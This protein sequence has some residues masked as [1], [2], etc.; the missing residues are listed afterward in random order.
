MADEGTDNK[1]AVVHPDRMY[2]ISGAALLAVVNTLDDLPR[3][4]NAIADRVESILCSAREMTAQGRADEEVVAT[5]DVANP[6]LS[7]ASVR[8]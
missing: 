5:G 3:R 1:A 8:A 4:H 2:A 7:G 6:L